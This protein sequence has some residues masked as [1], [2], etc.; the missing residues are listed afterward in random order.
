MQRNFRFILV[1]CI[2]LSLVSI[3]FVS[4][5]PFRMNRIPDG[6]KNFGC[7]TCH[8]DTQVIKDRNPFGKDYENIGIKAGDQY[9]LELG[10]LDSDK[11][12]FTNDQEFAANT[13]PGDPNSKPSGQRAPSNTGDEIT[14]AINRGKTIFM[15]AKLGKSGMSCNN[16]HIAGGTTGGKA[17]GMDIPTLKGAAAEFPKYKAPAKRVI[18]LLQMNNMCLT[19]MV[20][21]NALKLGSDDAVALA[22]YVTS[23]S[24]GIPVQVGAKK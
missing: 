3:A 9:T 17:M 19:M 21:G 2:C 15:N 18:T 14:K 4:S 12:G 11:D 20:K 23:L 7:H 8:V 10:K 6:G 24:N 13:N 5:R 22:A 1:V 16:C